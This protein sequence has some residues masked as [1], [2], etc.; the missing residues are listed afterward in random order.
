MTTNMIMDSKNI[1]KISVIIPLYNKAP[2]IKRA[3]D[4]VI[5]QTI[6][7]FEI[8]VIGGN[9]TDNGE[10]I[11]ASFDDSRIKLIKEEKV[12]VSAARNQ[13]VTIAQSN[14]ISF[15][16][17]DDEWDPKYL[18]TILKL[19]SL[20]PDAGLYSTAWYNISH[21]GECTVSKCYNIPENWVGIVPSVFRCA[22]IDGFFPGYTSSISIPKNIIIEIG[23][24]NEKYQ[25]GEDVDL[26]GRVALY[27]KN[28]HCSKP[29]VYY[30]HDDAY[31]LT[32][33]K[34]LIIL[35]EFP[36]Q[37]S[38]EIYFKN[39]KF[40]DKS[41]NHD[42]KLY[43][44]SLNICYTWNY[45]AIGDTKTARRYICKVHHKE[46]MKKKCILYI[47]TYIPENIIKCIN[48]SPF[49]RK[50]RGKK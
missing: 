5:S 39:E 24:F 3:I 49:L 25:M 30:R 32:T 43:L 42:L 8:L 41:Q 38:L 45:I 27:Y 4:S 13:G 47:R 20:Y 40:I 1:P 9:S 2:F 26:W 23:G 31:A 28:A 46:L 33:K 37:K 18:E 15:L 44:D 10:E 22:A 17:A 6:Q 16:D 21:N 12:G 50:L 35:N 48:N 19:Q 36:L 34:E 29:L 14:L 11:V 7:D